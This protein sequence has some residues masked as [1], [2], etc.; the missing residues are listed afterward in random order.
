MSGCE[1]KHPLVGN[2]KTVDNSGKEALIF[3]H[4]DHTF[5]AVGNGEKLPGQ[6]VWRDDTDPPQI[7]LNFEQ[8]KIVTIAEIEGNQLLIEPRESKE[9]MPTQFSDK[10]QKYRRQ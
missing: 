8:K 7:E 2:W 1:Q 5:E 6:W 10:V 4:A 9:D 3:F